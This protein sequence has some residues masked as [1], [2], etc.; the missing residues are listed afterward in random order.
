MNVGLVGV[1]ALGTGIAAGLVAAGHKVWAWDTAP[2]A[3]ERARALG[4]RVA[5][6]PIYLPNH[7]ELI[8]MALP[9][10]ADV[11]ATVERLL[12]T[13]GRGLILVDISTGDSALSR[14]NAEKAAAAGVAYLDARTL[15]VLQFLARTI[16]INNDEV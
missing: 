12:R 2:A 5:T 11:A 9:T 13:A 8:I 10:A 14:I 3:Q 16:N 15:D 6:D 7:T 4:C 1:G